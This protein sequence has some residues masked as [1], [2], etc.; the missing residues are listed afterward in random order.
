MSDIAH[1]PHAGAGSY[2]THD[3]SQDSLLQ[4]M[5]QAKRYYLY[6]VPIF[7]LLGVFSYYP[8]LMAVYYSF[9]NFNGISGKFIGLENFSDLATDRI[10]RASIGNAVKLL[11]ANMV[12]GLIPPLV[13]AELLFSLRSRRLGDF[14]RTAFLIPTLVPAIVIIMTWRYIYHARYGLINNLLTAIGLDFLTHD[15]LGSFDTALPAMIFF[16]F[17]WINA[18]SMLILLAAIIGIPRELI[19]A[20]R[21]DSTSTLQRIRHVDLPYI[22][23]AIRLVIVLN[24]IAT[25]Q[26][27]NLQFAMTGGGPGTATTVPA[28]HMFSQAFFSSRFGY[29]SAIGTLLFLVIAGLTVLTRRYLRSGIEYET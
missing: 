17:P 13:V 11:F 22:V 20:F 25:L 18:T 8:P 12:T 21:L 9:T 14:Y 4:R 23:G 6:L 3:E 1:T 10:F 16:G 28:F 5:W 27:F 15:W 26:G 29:G 7:A 19:D 24:I 2:Q